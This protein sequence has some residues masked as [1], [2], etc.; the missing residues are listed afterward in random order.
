MKYIKLFE[1]YKESFY[2]DDIN[3]NITSTVCDIL[4]DQ[5]DEGLYDINC[6]TVGYKTL[7]EVG[8]THTDN[9]IVLY[10][11]PH[12]HE[13]I[14]YD[15]NII[16]LKLDMKSLMPYLERV[17]SY[18]E[19]EGRN[20][21]FSLQF[22][23]TRNKMKEINVDK[24]EDIPMDT[25]EYESISMAFSLPLGDYLVRKNINY[26]KTLNDV[27]KTNESLED[28]N[29]TILTLKDICIELEDEGFNILFLLSRTDNCRIFNL[30]IQKRTKDDILDYY[31]V[32][33]DEVVQRVIDYL[34]DKLVDIMYTNSGLNSY[35]KLDP[36]RNPQPTMELY[37]LIIEFKI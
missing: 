28:N 37:N 19:S 33:V 20:V 31:W 4:Q 11:L 13:H 5:I 17:V 15:Y 10:I 29:E 6:F 18:V 21:S 27:L 8:A 12:Y 34:G 7:K 3:V 1:A 16:Y 2:P 30:L 32:E 26:L 24:I 14:N 36:S 35:Y 9:A 22:R 23:T 25:R